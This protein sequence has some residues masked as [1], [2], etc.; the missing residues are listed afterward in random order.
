MRH[1]R[2]PRLVA[3]FGELESREQALTIL[4]HL[5]ACAPSLQH[6]L[7]AAFDAMSDLE[8]G[9]AALGS[10][11]SACEL[12]QSV[13]ICLQD[14]GPSSV[15]TSLKQVQSSHGV[16]PSILY[17]PVPVLSNTRL[18]C[19]CCSSALPASGSRADDPAVLSHHNI[20]R[21]IPVMTHTF[22]FTAPAH[23]G[24][25]FTSFAA[26]LS[27]RPLLQHRPMYTCRTLCSAVHF[28]PVCDQMIM[29]GY[30]TCEGC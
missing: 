29:E 8:H 27:Y 11:I 18:P 19:S 14:C 16:N 10:V 30:G 23:G 4:Q 13:N 25:G 1:C 12:L 6:L 21:H 5:P 9:V 22:I 15:A 20:E 28:G 17:M 26:L 3:F 24:H 2:C 7:L